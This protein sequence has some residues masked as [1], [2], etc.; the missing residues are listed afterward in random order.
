M[1]KAVEQKLNRNVIKDDKTEDIEG[2]RAEVK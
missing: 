1:P 2:Y